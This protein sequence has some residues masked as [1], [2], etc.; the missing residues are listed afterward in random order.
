MSNGSK[1]DGWIGQ[2]W[3]LPVLVF[4]TA[5]ALAPPQIVAANLNATTIQAFDRY[6]Q[7]SE[8]RMAALRPGDSFLWM[9]ALPTEDRAK[10]YAEL[11]H[12]EILVQRSEEGD[13]PTGIAVEGGG[14]IHDWTAIIFVPGV[15]LA[16]TLKLLQD[17][18]RAAEFYQPDVTRSKLLSHSGDDFHV[19]L[20]LKRKEVI[21]LVFDTEYDV[22]YASLD[23]THAQSRSYST[24][25]AEVQRA[26]ES[27]E[28]DKP[29]GQ[30]AVFSGDSI[31]TGASSRPA[32]ASTSSAKQS[33]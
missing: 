3:L 20:R 15:T 24:R 23:A 17:Y 33:P 18:N 16:Q 4:A 7:K 1:P 32:V 21:T 2:R 8:A 30:D 13:S 29:V 22:R 25:V 10:S 14:L 26:G 12:G 5:F 31:L 28:F 9:D 19:Y 11:Q 27:G 6:I